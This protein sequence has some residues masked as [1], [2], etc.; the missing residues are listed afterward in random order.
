MKT[1]YFNEFNV[2][3]GNA[4]YFP[5]VSGILC[6]AA[7]SQ[8]RLRDAYRFKPFIFHLDSAENILARYDEA[9]DV[10][11]FSVAM[12]NEQL[13]LYL[14]QTIK[15]RWPD[16]LIVFGGPQL[17]HNPEEYFEA[18]PFIDVGVRAEGEEA[19]MALLDRNLESRDF[20][21]VPNVSFRHPETG[22]FVYN[23]ETPTF[24]RD[25]DNYPSPYLTGLFDYMFDAHPE[26]EFQAIIETNRGCPFLCTFCYWGRGGTSRRYRYHAMERVEGELDWCG[27]NEIRYVFNADSNF[28]MHRRDMEIGEMIVA[29]KQK[30]GFPEKFRTCWGK[31]TDENIFRIAGLLHEHDMEKGITLARQSQ[32]KQVLANIK[33][34]NIKMDTYSSLQRRFNDLDVPVYTEMILGLPGESYESWLDGI[35]EMLKSGLKNQLFIYQCEAY[36]NTEL[37]D[38]AYQEKFGIKLKRL[39]LREIHG[40]IRDESWVPEYHDIVV[41]TADMPHNDWRRMNRMSMMTMLLHSM[42]LGFYVMRYMTDRYPVNFTPFIEFVTELKMAEGTGSQFRREMELFDAYLDRMMS[43]EGRGVVMPNHGGIYWDAE[44][45]AF[46][47]IAEDL[48]GFYDELRDMVCQYLDHN[49]VAYDADEV[50]EVVRYQRMR[51]PGPTLPD[52]T[53]WTFRYNLP[54]YFHR[55]FGTDPIA[56]VPEKQVL[57]CQP[58]DFQGARADF[59]IRTILWG[60]KSGALLVA[61]RWESL[62]RGGMTSEMQFGITEESQLVPLP[63]AANLGTA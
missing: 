35:E 6:A 14:A 42:K 13:S 24:E 44:E 8:P 48:D 11:C 4:T 21:G 30:Y 49:G 39:E 52:L 41:E 46:L 56:V 63:R 29:T 25:M 10:A 37:G 7:K 32:N 40:S 59:A 62:D 51:M 5:L 61:C 15:E 31:N 43:G 22:A 53:E 54:E 60:R 47:R 27:R 23:V 58:V 55:C 26:I 16:C 2:R 38:P 9:P 19:F 28:G 34:G 45:A 17:P 3:M 1:V 33:R 36:P 50:A 20:S 57:E 18:N 12:W